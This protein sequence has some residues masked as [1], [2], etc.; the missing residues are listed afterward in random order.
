MF[1]VEFTKSVAFYHLT[2]TGG[3]SQSYSATPDTTVFAAVLPMDRK[4]AAL[5]GLDLTD[6]KELYC[7]SSADIKDQDKVIIS[8][9]SANYYVKH[10]F[11]ADYTGELAHKRVTVAKNA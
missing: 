2:T 1:P 9:D 3:Q 5:E 6:P 10:I 7:P 8:G 4:D 11:T